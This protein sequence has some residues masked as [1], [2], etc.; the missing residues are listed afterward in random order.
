MPSNLR[1]ALSFQWIIALL[2]RSLGS[3]KYPHH[4]SCLELIMPAHFR[5]LT[6]GVLVVGEKIRNNKYAGR[7]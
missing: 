3:L 7:S 4:I 2:A 1:T 5:I 6:C